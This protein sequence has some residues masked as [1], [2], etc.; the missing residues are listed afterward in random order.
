MLWKNIASVG[1]YNGFPPL[2]FSSVATLYAVNVT[3]DVD[4][5]TVDITARELVRRMARF[6]SSGYV[7]SG[8]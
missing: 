7:R 8:L 6:L 4:G 2:C 1:V 3:F 5:I